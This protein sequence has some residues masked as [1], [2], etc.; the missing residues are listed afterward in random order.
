MYSTQ[1]TVHNIIVTFHGDRWLPD[2]P[3]GHMGR[4]IG[5]DH[6]A[7]ELKLK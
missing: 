2:L 3:G 5:V 4:Y 7:T 6:Y 1:N